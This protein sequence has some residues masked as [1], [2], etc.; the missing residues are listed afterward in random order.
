MVVS[1]KV[2]GVQL[3]RRF[4]RKKG[5]RVKILS[6]VGLANAALF[7]Q[8]EVKSSIA[9]RRAEPTSVDTGQ[10][11]NSVDFSVGKASATVFSNVKHAPFIEFGTS[12]VRP[13]RHFNNSLARS[14]Q[15]IR[16]IMNKEIR[17]I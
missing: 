3:A 11:L 16:R 4:I 7:L 14:K 6:V 8:G 17:K 12:R 9:G 10:L 2:R 1:I 15:S 5:R 13:R